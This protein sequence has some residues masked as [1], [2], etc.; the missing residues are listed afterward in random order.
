MEREGK[1]KRR[2]REG[3]RVASSQV[4]WP[5]T[6]AVQRRRHRAAGAGA[7]WGPGRRWFST[8]AT[9]VCR[10]H[11]VGYP[12]AD[13]S[14]RAAT[15]LPAIGNL[16]CDRRTDGRTDSGGSRPTYFGGRG[17]SVFSFPSPPSTSLL[18]HF[19]SS[20]FSPPPSFSLPAV[21]SKKR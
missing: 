16:I 3:R 10:R 9:A 21:R 14:S 7:G 15:Q 20:P 13:Q 4:L 6:A 2:G 5:R 17:S 8:P 19:P 1:G 11:S 12:S 18:F